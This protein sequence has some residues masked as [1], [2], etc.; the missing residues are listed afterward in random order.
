MTWVKTRD[1]HIDSS[2]YGECVVNSEF[3]PGE[4]TGIDLHHPEDIQDT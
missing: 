1:S 4:K 2:C 3:S